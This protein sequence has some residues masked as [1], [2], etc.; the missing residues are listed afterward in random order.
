MVRHRPGSLT[1]RKV[2]PE[3]PGTTDRFIE[4]WTAF[5]VEQGAPPETASRDVAGRLAAAL[6]RDG[7]TVFL[8]ESVGEAVGYV[9]L[10]ESPLTALSE[11]SSIWV[12]QLYVVPSARRSGTAK[13]LLAAA[14]RVAE[15]RGAEQIAACVPAQARESNRFFA[16]L[17]FHSF[18]VR[19]VTSTGALRRRLGAPEDRPALDEVLQRR[20]SLR[21]R[22]GRPAR[23]LIRG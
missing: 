13:A 14:A 3:T 23:Q 21:A 5:L 12:D 2:T 9:A 7:V 8:A 6:E 18:V 1:I 16:R 22:A 17:G 20:R 19:R 11:G 15:E 10:L 4:L